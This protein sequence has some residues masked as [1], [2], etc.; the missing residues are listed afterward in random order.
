MYELQELPT[1]LTPTNPMI[2]HIYL[3]VFVFERCS[4]QLVQA[5]S[6]VCQELQEALL[7]DE[8]LT[9][10]NPMKRHIHLSVLG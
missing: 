2:R 3:S 1:Y 6:P 9:P 10:S 7:Q 8:Y 5:G 4:T